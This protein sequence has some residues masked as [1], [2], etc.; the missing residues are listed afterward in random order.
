MIFERR[1]SKQVAGHEPVGQ[2]L[3]GRGPGPGGG[4]EGS[5]LGESRVFG[6][7]YERFVTRVQDYIEAIQ[8]GRGSSQAF[9]PQHDG[10]VPA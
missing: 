8:E 10:S 4:G 2:G 6:V 3:L 5:N 9:N 1:P 7:V